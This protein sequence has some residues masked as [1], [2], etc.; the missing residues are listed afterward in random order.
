MITE[1]GIYSR[2]REAEIIKSD[3]AKTDFKSVWIRY[4]YNLA[5][6]AYEKADHVFTLFEHNGRLK[7]NWAVTLRKLPLCPTASIWSGLRP[8][9]N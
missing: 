3:W 9:R 5:K 8:F 7:R 4:F 6:L 2:E 1:H